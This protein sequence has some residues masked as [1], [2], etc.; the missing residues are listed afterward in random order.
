MSSGD[1]EYRLQEATAKMVMQ[2]VEACWNMRHRSADSSSVAKYMGVSRRYALSALVCAEQLRMVESQNRSYTLLKTASDVS[3]ASREEYP[4]IF[5]K[6][7]VAY[8]PFVLFVAQ[9]EKGDSLLEAARKVGIVYRFG[10]DADATRR[11]FVGWGVY[12]NLLE[13]KDDDTIS[14]SVVTE[15]LDADT[16]RELVEAMRSEF[17]ARIYIIRRVGEDL[18]IFMG[19]SIEYVVSAIINHIRNPRNSIEDSGKSLEDFLRRICKRLGTDAS[20]CN[21]IHQIAQKIYT[22]RN[23]TNK[24]REI[25]EGINAI[26]IAAAHSIDKSASDIWKINPEIAMEVVLMTLSLMKSIYHYVVLGG[27]LVL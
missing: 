15:F 13:Q 12:S 1:R 6:H 22:D 9:V 7:L 24:H 16:V 2:A 25:C 21:G 20:Q 27:E 5:G 10:L 19:Q 14:V 18:F 23:I 26:R 8:P 11:L 4:I 17:N 3:R